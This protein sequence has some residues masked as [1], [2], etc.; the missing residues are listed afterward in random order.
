MIGPGCS[1]TCEVVSY[2]SRG[3]NIP[4]I[5]YS[6]TAPALSCGEKHPLF[7]RTVAPDSSKGPALIAFMKYNGWNK[8]AI[9]TST[10]S[11]YFESGLALKTQLEAAGMHVLRP[12]AFRPGFYQ[13]KPHSDCQGI[14]TGGLNC[15]NPGNFRDYALSEIKREKMRIILLLAYPSDANAVATHAHHLHMSTNGWA[16]LWVGAVGPV[17]REISGWLYLRPHIP[18]SFEMDVFSE[19]VRD[20]TK[21]YFNVSEMSVSI[22]ADTVDLTYSLALYNAGVCARMCC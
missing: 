5:S 13:D 17:V 2:L 12:A 14:V 6:C 18:S 9:L 4:Q 20:Y 19:L 1:E 10:D 7:S 15:S 22:S 3:P 21:D 8:V 11:V 16:W